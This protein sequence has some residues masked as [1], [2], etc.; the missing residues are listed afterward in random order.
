MAAPALG[1]RPPGA[2]ATV[3]RREEATGSN[4]MTRQLSPA[5]LQRDRSA[6][7]VIDMQERLMPAIADADAVT[8]AAGIL[9]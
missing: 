3:A 8:R 5:L 6:L 9:I 1:L 4:A 7:V 2:W